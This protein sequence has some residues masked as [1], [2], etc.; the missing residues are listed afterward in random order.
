MSWKYV[1]NFKLFSYE[2]EASLFL[3]P[4]SLR[5][6]IYERLSTKLQTLFPTF[7]IVSKKLPIKTKKLFYLDYGRILWPTV[8]V[9]QKPNLFQTIDSRFQSIVSR[10]TYE[11]QPI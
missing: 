6:W 1:G 7:K 3:T 9:Y 11:N 10:K 4:N 2:S 8:F 5:D